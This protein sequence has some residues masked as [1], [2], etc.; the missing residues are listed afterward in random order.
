MIT[1]F[2][3]SLQKHAF[4]HQDACQSQPTVQFASESLNVRAQLRPWKV[5]RDTGVL[6]KNLKEYGTFL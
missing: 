2:Q 4:C 3:I 5:F 6:A 1:L